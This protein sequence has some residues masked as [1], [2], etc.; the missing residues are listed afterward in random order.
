MFHADRD[1]VRGGRRSA[2]VA[3][4]HAVT[5]KVRILLSLAAPILGAYS[6]FAQEAVPMMIVFGI[7]RESCAS[8]QSSASNQRD[9]ASWILGFWTGI[10]QNGLDK[11]SRMVGSK[12]DGLGILAEVKKTC[13]TRPSMTLK[14]ATNLTHFEMSKR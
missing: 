13:E 1:L 14:D 5:M 7:G 12:T 3:G 6:S 2:R 4:A 9:G 10:N 8:W 11:K